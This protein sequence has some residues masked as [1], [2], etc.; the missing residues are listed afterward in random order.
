MVAA[1]VVGEDGKESVRKYRCEGK[2]LQA[3]HLLLK[4]IFLSESEMMSTLS[5]EVGAFPVH[6]LVVANNPEAL[7]LA[8]EIF[9]ANPLLLTTLH[10]TTRL[11]LPLFL[12]ESILH[13]LCVNQREAMLLR[14][15]ALA[16]ENLNDADLNNLIL[17]QTTGVFFESPPM[18]L[19]GG[20]ALSYACVFDLREAVNALLDTG[21]V[22]FNEQSSR[23]KLTGFLPLH[24]VMANGR[25]GVYEWMTKQ[26]PWER[27]ADTSLLTG[28]GT[29]ADLRLEHLTT[30][31]LSAKLGNNRMFMEILRHQCDVQW[32]WGPVTCYRINLMGID[33][34]GHG[35]GDI[36]EL[37]GDINARREL[38]EMLRKSRRAQTLRCCVCSSSVRNL[39]S[40]DNFMDG[41]LHSL[42]RQKMAKFRSSI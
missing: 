18:R 36:M 25:R 4:A 10:T 11:G 15:I 29:I 42:F 28:E 14:L 17:A 2:Q 40:V 7:E 8:A 6:A 19:Y 21:L 27:R 22:S 31:Q 3:L 37:V 39:H 35:A 38:Q 16:V 23:C 33:S 9:E 5:D 12:G 26:L 13:I 1:T 41:F 20:T 24:A 30:L 32:V 34:A